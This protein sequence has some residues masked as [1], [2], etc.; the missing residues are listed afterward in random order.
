MLFRLFSILYSFY[1][2]W[3]EPDP[4]D[5]S[6]ISLSILFA[7]SANFLISIIYY[8]SGW[9]I[10]SFNLWPVGII[11]L[12]IMG[13]FVYL[14]YSKKEEY[15]RKVSS[16]NNSKIKDWVGLVVLLTLFIMGWIAIEVYRIGNLR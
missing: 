8:F 15:L 1:G 5:R 16:I 10:L 14:I 13:I 2:R 4:F 12:L 11:L 9:Q 6:A 3:G 7:F